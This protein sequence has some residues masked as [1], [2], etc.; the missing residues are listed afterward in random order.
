[1]ARGSSRS[2]PI[3]PGT[4]PAAVVVEAFAARP[5]PGL[6]ALLGPEAAQRLHAG[7]RARAR[8]WAAA[9]ARG[10][11]FEATSLAAAA[12]AVHGHDGPLLLA[13]PDVPALD[14]AV[15]RVALDDLAAGCDL[16]VGVAHDALPYLVALPRPDDALAELA[17]EG[18][19]GGILPV[20]A[21]RGLT[22]G[23]LPHH[24]R[25]ASAADARAFALDPLTPPDLAEL[26]RPLARG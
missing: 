2:G 1:M 11:A 17:A 14:A 7:M 16:V 24:R 13:A 21:D 20:F 23:M 8:R 25:L 10:R 9:A 3:S 6:E 12:A 22:L 18:F 15:A 19:A 26:L 5:D 4:E